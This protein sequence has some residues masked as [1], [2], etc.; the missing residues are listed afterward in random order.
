[1]PELTLKEYVEQL[2][3]D[4]KARLEYEKLLEGKLGPSDELS[5]EPRRIWPM[6]S[7]IGLG[8]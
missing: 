8:D 3:E 5:M 2:P 6:E 4:H 1:M 7:R